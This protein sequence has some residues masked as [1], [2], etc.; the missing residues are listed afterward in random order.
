MVVPPV[1]GRRGHLC[2]SSDRRTPPPRGCGPA[3]ALCRTRISTPS[4]PLGSPWV[5]DSLSSARAGGVPGQ[6][7][8]TPPDGAP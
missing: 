5:A 8:A 1:A 3:P 4:R 2:S 6:M 7:P